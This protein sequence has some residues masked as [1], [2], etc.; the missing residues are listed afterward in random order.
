MK[1]PVI[2]F[3]FGG[4]IMQTYSRTPRH[5]WDTRLGLKIGTVEQIVHGSESWRKAQL[6]LISVD[7]YW[8]DVANQLGISQDALM[9]LQQD[10][11]S[12][13]KLDISIINLIKRL[14]NTGH[15]VALLS[16]D[17]TALRPKLTQLGIDSLFN[18]LVIS[19]E[20]GVMKPDAAAY[21]AVLA[22]VPCNAQDAI[23]IDDMPANI[24]GAEAV[25][26][27]GILYRPGMD[28]EAELANFLKN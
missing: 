12:G 23:F 21:E 9:Q 17:S 14:H 7:D 10:Y 16:N 22:R 19:A 25:G 24:Q 26:M 18:P 13:D 28:L 6:G 5:L 2:I 27:K 4:V 20:I 1:T 15:T 8:Q 11:F 3:D